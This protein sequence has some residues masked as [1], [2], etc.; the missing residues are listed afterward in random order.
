MVVNKLGV[1]IAQEEAS[2]V[3]PT[4][5]AEMPI[6][7]GTK[8]PLYFHDGEGRERV[9]FKGEAVSAC[10]E[11]KIVCNVNPDGDLW[12]QVRLQSGRNGWTNQRR[13]FLG[14]SMYDN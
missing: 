10:C 2:A 6:P 7:A 14:T 4:G 13:K 8:L 1:C 3:L 5:G 12:L 9:E 11:G